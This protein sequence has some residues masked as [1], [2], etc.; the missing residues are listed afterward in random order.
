MRGINEL[1]EHDAKWRT[2]AL[3]ITCNKMTADDLVQD[4]YLKLMDK[5]KDLSDYYVTMTLKSIFTDGVKKTTMKN[6]TQGLVNEEQIEDESTKFEADDKQQALLDKIQSLPFHQQEFIAESYDNSLRKIE[7]IYDINY[8]FIYRELHKGLEDV[9]GKNGKDKMYS[10]NN[11]KIRKA[12]KNNE[13]ELMTDE[14]F[15]LWVEGIINSNDI[16]TD[17]EFEDWTEAII[18]KK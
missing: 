9:L 15:A 3:K 11:L 8:G 4:M 7:G 13:E 12:K 17:K 1:A 5:D 16:M 18:K 6:R 2:I 10:N 14:E